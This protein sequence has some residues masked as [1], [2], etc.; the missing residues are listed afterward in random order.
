MILKIVLVCLVLLCPFI[1]YGQFI[2]NKIMD[3][4]SLINQMKEIQDNLLKYLDNESDVEEYYQN[5]IQLLDNYD[6]F[7]KP[8][9]FK[10]VLHLL[11]QISI[12]HHRYTHFYEKFNTILTYFKDTII[13]Y[14]N[15]N[16]IFDIFSED[17]VL[18][19]FL[20]QNDA[21]Q[22]NDQLVKKILDHKYIQFFI[23]EVT[24]YFKEQPFEVKSTK[25]KNDALF[26]EC[27]RLGESD[28][29]VCKLI[30][31]DNIEDFITFVEKN[32]YSLDSPTEITIFNTNKLLDNKRT[33]LIEYAAFHGSIQI[34]KYLYLNKVKL[35]DSLW[36]HAIHGDNEEII[37]ILEQN[38]VKPYGGFERLYK[39]AIICHNYDMA[40]YIQMKHLKRKKI[41]YF[42]ESIQSFN[43]SFFEKD[44]ASHLNEFI[45]YDYQPIVE[46]L[47]KNNK[48]D[49]N[50]KIIFLFF[51]F[52]SNFIMTVLSN[53]V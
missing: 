26:E 37:A 29:Y 7:N 20:I 46:I 12:N 43:F 39:E 9:E 15:S 24:S 13:K 35:S 52:K 44:F 25:E 38:K 27:R 1:F 53:I 33:T 48:I 49:I 21:I 10:L 6:I 50:K 4:E 40:Y 22:I 51:F 45:R 47:L 19:L 28:T 17:K 42:T 34:F 41:E 31:N 36:I 5:F 18:I 30:R 3:I 14:F 8:S 23:K 2:C 16:E 11:L 32:N